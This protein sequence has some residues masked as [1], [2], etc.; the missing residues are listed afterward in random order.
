MLFD[1][2]YKARLRPDI[3]SLKKKKKPQ[4]LKGSEC[5]QG[6]TDTARIPTQIIWHPVPSKVLPLTWTVPFFM[7]LVI[8]PKWWC[9]AR[10]FQCQRCWNTGQRNSHQSRE[11]KSQKQAPLDLWKMSLNFSHD[12]SSHGRQCH[13]WSRVGSNSQQILSHHLTW[14]FPSW[15]TLSNN[16]SNKTTNIGINL[17]PVGHTKT[18]A[19]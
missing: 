5:A 1:H 16:S 19:G 14:H 15:E 2:W 6:H 7:T 3:F 12:F 9:A 17:S 13:Q 4:A 8:D 10:G 11:V 18:T